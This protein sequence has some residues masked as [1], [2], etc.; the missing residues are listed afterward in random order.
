MQ[1]ETT[2]QLAYLNKLE[3]MPEGCFMKCEAYHMYKKDKQFEKNGM[4]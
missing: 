3:F 2:L 1:V 4:V